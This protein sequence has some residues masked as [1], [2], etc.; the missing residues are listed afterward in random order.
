MKLSATGS[1]V[2]EIEASGLS[3]GCEV[4]R[5][6]VQIYGA[7]LYGYILLGPARD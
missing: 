3:V 5:E 1:A 4:V 7:S 6:V 2:G